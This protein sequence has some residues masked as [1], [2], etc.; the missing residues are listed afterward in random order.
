MVC[1]IPA[2]FKINVA[3]I[4]SLCRPSMF[5]IVQPMFRIVQVLR[6]DERHCGTNSCS[7][8]KISWSRS[9]FSDIGFY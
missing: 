9:P 7:S 3:N 2:F 8:T 6:H 1:K 5:W 4:R